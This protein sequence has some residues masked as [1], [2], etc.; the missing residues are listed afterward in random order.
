MNTAISPSTVP[1]KVPAP[2]PTI[3]PNTTPNNTEPETTKTETLTCE[4]RDEAISRLRK[5]PNNGRVNSLGRLAGNLLYILDIP[6]DCP[7]P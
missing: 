7:T 5:L 1:S 6:P 4:Q 3:T 2:T